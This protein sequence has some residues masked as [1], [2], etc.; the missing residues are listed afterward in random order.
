MK[1]LLA[2][3]LILFLTA[4]QIVQ[5]FTQTLSKTASDAYILR[6]S[7]N[8]DSALILLKNHLK[9]HSLDAI[10][11][12]EYART[13]YHITP[14]HRDSLNRIVFSKQ[15]SV[16]LNLAHKSIDKAIQIYPDNYRFYWAKIWIPRAQE[17]NLSGGSY[18]DA[19]VHII[20]EKIGY[21]EKA[22]ALS[23][24]NED[25]LNALKGYQ[26]MLETKQIQAGPIRI[27]RSDSQSNEKDCIE[28]IYHE[29]RKFQATFGEPMP[30]DEKIILCE[31]VR[32][33]HLNDS[34]ATVM[35][36]KLYL[37]NEEPERAV[38]ILKETLN[39]DPEFYKD[40]LLMA[41]EFY[42]CSWHI[43]MELN[44]EYIQMAKD[45]ISSYLA[46]EPCIP[47]KIFALEKLAGIYELNEET[48]QAEL[49]KEEA[50]KLDPYIYNRS[51]WEDLY[52]PLSEVVSQ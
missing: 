18:T 52:T 34:R 38:E 37:E 50:Q 25:L 26:Y 2:Y 29:Y 11:N 20:E 27:W 30:T 49:L 19:N 5:G 15:D 40:Y 14:P 41:E 33:D 32:K 1:N 39:N 48:E 36:A 10:A 8:A 23:P 31:K 4:F 6:M 28:Y 17:R 7:G 24:E 3:S 51:V 13:L 21:L 44:A 22:L 16:N 35:L 42:R 47:H 12:Y 9:I 46:T 43:F 45:L